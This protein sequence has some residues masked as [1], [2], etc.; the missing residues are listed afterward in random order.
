MNDCGI[1]PDQTASPYVL[2]Y[3]A[4]AE[5][6][7]WRTTSHYTPGNRGVGLYAI[8]FQMPIGSPVAA[9]RSGV[10]IAVREQFPDNNNTDL[11][12]NYVMVRHA[13]STVARYLHLTRNGALVDEGDS[14]AAGQVIARSGNSGQS[15]GSHLHFDVQ[16]CGPNLP[17]RYN[18]L[19][20]GRTLPVSFRNTRPHACGLAPQERYRSGF[21]AEPHDGWSAPTR[22]EYG[23]KEALY[24]YLLGHSLGDADHFRRAF[25]EQGRL[26]WVRDGQLR[27]RSVTEYAAGASGRPA[28][29]ESRRRRRVTSMSI[30][31]DVAAATVELDYP[32]GRFVDYMALVRIGDEWRIISKVYQPLPR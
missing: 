18:Q 17:P 6:L 31:G 29:D 4:G 24:H 26:Y 1:Y 12:E 5:H 21:V 3:P 10:V 2:P 30:T 16:Q 11:E 20:C 32:S 22:A 13:D 28:E 14:V 27:T 19:P 7:V 23:V 15:G 9:A 25:H 8:D